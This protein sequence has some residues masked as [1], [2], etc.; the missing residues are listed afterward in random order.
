MLIVYKDWEQVHE[1]LE[2]ADPVFRSI[3]IN[4]SE[5]SRDLCT[6]HAQRVISKAICEDIWKPFSSEFTALQPESSSVLGK[7]SDEIYQSDHGGRTAKFWNARTMQA[8]KSLPAISATSRCS[9]STV[10]PHPARTDSI[11]SKV[12]VLSPLLSSSQ[13]ESLRIDLVNLVNSAVD[14]WDNGQAGGSKITVSLLLERAHREEWRSQQFDPA[15]EG[16]ETNPDLSSTTRPRIFPLFPRVL[17]PGVGNL[18]NHGSGLPGSW[19]VDSDLTIIHPGKGLPEW[20]PLV[21]RGQVEQEERKNFFRTALENAKKHLQSTKRASGNGR[22][23]SRG[24]VT[25]GIPSEQWKRGGAIEFI[26]K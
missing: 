26:E 13:D 14:V 20:S 19:P 8:L 16:D 24:S 15:C 7:I 21:V 18:V 22:R 4:D 3:P 6:A 11:I 25:S 12:F 1:E 9:E 2:A 23:D 5:D 17:A 10:Y